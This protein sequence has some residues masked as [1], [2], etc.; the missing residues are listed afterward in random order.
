MCLSMGVLICLSIRLS[1][2]DPSID[3]FIILSIDLFIDSS[4]DLSI[5]LF[6]YRNI[7]KY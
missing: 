2:I 3:L 1:L 6:L 4:I 5:D 7:Y